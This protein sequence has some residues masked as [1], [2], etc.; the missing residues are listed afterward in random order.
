M[1]NKLIFSIVIVLL[2]LGGCIFFLFARKYDISELTPENYTKLLKIEDIHTLSDTWST[3]IFCGARVI[4]FN[5]KIARGNE[6]WDVDSSVMNS[7][8]TYTILNKT[9][10]NIYVF[11]YP[12]TSPNILYSASIYNVGK[13]ENGMIKW[14]P[15]VGGKGIITKLLYEEEF[16]LK[17]T[18]MKNEDDILIK[19]VGDFFIIGSVFW[20]KNSED[21]KHLTFKLYKKNKSLF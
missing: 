18:Q 17:K 4:I 5:P 10:L 21:V 2:L 16:T 7:S 3:D 9:N 6:N 11:V 8:M 19:D 13:D 1:P 14:L 12:E 15:I 20:D